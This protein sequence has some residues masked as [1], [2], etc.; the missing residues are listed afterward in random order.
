M[1]FIIYKFNSVWKN[2]NQMLAGRTEEQC[3]PHPFGLAPGLK[4]T[5]E[6]HPSETQEKGT[7]HALCRCRT[8]EPSA[9][10]RRRVGPRSTPVS[11]LRL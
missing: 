7:Q 9:N 8:S 4:T 3:G 6:A 11:L 1:G 2:R 5:T 10:H